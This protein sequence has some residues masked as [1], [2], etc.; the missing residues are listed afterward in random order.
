M[1]YGTGTYDYQRN[2]AGSPAPRVRPEAAGI[3]DK[4]R[5][6][7]MHNCLNQPQISHFGRAS[8]SMN[9]ENGPMRYNGIKSPIL[10]DPV[11]NGGRYS[12]R[13]ARPVPRVRPEAQEVAE[14][15]KGCMGVLFNNYGKPDPYDYCNTRDENINP[16][17]GPL[18]QAGVRSPILVDPMYRSGEY[19]GRTPRPVPR[20]R[21]EAEEIATKSKG[22]VG[23]LFVTNERRYNE[24]SKPRKQEK[25]HTAA[26]VR[27]MREIQRNSRAREQ[28]KQEKKNTP[29][30]ALWKST[31]YEGVESK[32]KNF[33]QVIK[34]PPNTELPH[35]APAGSRRQENFNSEK[36]KFQPTRSQTPRARSPS[37]NFV[38]RNARAAKSY[39]LKRSRSQLA[40]RDSDEKY[41]QGLRN[42]E[43][44][45]KGKTPSYLRSRQRQWD[46]QERDRIR[47]TP[48]PSVPEG[49]TVL[50]DKE[51]KE[52]LTTLRKSLH[53]SEHTTL[54]KL[55]PDTEYSGYDTRQYTNAHNVSDNLR[56]L[57]RSYKLAMEQYPNNIG[58]QNNYN[59]QD[60]VVNTPDSND[61]YIYDDYGGKSDEI[62]ENNKRAEININATDGSPVYVYAPKTIN[63]HPEI[64]TQQYP[65]D[66]YTSVDQ[67]YIPEG[68]V[69]NTGYYFDES[70]QISP[71]KT[72]TFRTPSPDNGYHHTSSILKPSD[73]FKSS[74]PQPSDHYGSSVLQNRDHLT[75][76][77]HQPSNHYKSSIHQ[78]VDNYNGSLLQPSGRYSNSILPP[79][80]RYSY[81]I[82]RHN[83]RGRSV[84]SPTDHYVDSMLQPS[85]RL[86]NFTQRPDGNDH[87]RSV[88]P[89]SGE[90]T[91]PIPPPSDQYSQAR[92]PHPVPP[93]NGRNLIPTAYQEAFE[94]KKE[95]FQPTAQQE[96][97]E[98]HRLLPVRSADTMGVRNRKTELEKQIMEVDEAIKVFERPRVF[99]RL[100]E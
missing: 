89:I 100:G 23:N 26:N 72:V 21:P 50:P 66:P 59:Y 24:I 75:S 10:V 37:P 15:S 68:D 95:L 65:E 36:E 1:Q 43:E 90:Y 58:T 91:H 86:S 67:E 78:P 3:A 55:Q 5:G 97:L 29:V 63:Y 16:E 76:S 52:T 38:A 71:R 41:Q 61:D 13:S 60:S 6:T 56:K 39:E 98:R 2:F 69:S 85:G 11:Y 84:A 87:S 62:Y 19:S 53:Y 73:R 9:M 31:Q 49:H 30:K 33:M 82:D 8:Q 17:K 93:S 7:A 88:A 40:L 32:V 57:R 12:N 79:S 4:H 54:T 44:T 47:N 83:D 18:R 77:I 74:V 51:R 64:Q 28:E 92:Y 14:K 20:V 34:P 94:G 80:D 22:T 35:S 48:D 96:L 70:P 99:V 42:Y 46:T 27:R 25:N 45:V 81:P